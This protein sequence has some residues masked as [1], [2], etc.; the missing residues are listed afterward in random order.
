MNSAKTQITRKNVSAPMRWIVNNL[1]FSPFEDVLHFGEG[2]AFADTEA[3]RLPL[4]GSGPYVM[5]FDPNSPHVWKRDRTIINP[6][7]YTYAHGVSIYVFNTLTHFDRK[8]AFEDMMRCCDNLII[9]VRTDKVNGTPVLGYDG[10][11]TKRGTFQTQLDTGAWTEW[12]KRV[13]P[14]GTSVTL[15]QSNGSYCILGIK[16]K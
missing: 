1:Y 9:A 6:E 4:Y 10:V 5:A 11:T 16:R 3:L 12:F 2:K 13:S 14:E 7:F 15:L 8:A